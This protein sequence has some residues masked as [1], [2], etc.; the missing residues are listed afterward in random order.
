[1]SR[2][3]KKNPKGTTPRRRRRVLL[4]GKLKA[5]I[6]LVNQLRLTATSTDEAAALQKLDAACHRVLDD[7]WF[8]MGE[9]LKPPVSPSPSLTLGQSLVIGA[10][11]TFVRKARYPDNP[12]NLAAAMYLLSM[13]RSQLG[14]LAITDT[15]ADLVATLEKKRQWLARVRRCLYL[16]NKKGARTRGC[17]RY[18]FDGSQ[19]GNTRGCPGTPHTVRVDEYEAG[20][21][22]RRRRA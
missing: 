2:P 5:G 16:F 22:S 8:A 14:E 17:L 15:L 11:W 6:A 10:L 9:R 3:A 19:A 12:W 21:F 1:M 4:P 13:S 18:F 20:P 7:W